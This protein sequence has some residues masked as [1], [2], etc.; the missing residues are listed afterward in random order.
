M[1]PQQRKFSIGRRRSCDIPL[2]H[3]SVS[4]HHAEL[5]F[6]DNG[7]LLLT[8]CNSTNGTFLLQGAGVG[9]PVHQELVSPMDQVRFGDIELSV[10]ELLEALRLKFPQFEQR[11]S[12][13]Q[14]P[15]KPWI[16]G[17]QLIRCACGCIKPAGE[18]C[19]ECGR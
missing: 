10:R 17:R 14:Q 2:A 16:Q 6:L 4:G 3:E 9:K 8:D 11:V 12:G 13:K 1:R 15:E 18:A 7:K 19:P 5:D